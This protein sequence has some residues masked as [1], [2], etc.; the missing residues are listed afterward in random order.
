M[1]HLCEKEIKNNFIA[2]E[3]ILVF[4]SYVPEGMGIA[5]FDGEQYQIATRIFEP[6]DIVFSN[7]VEILP[8]D[9]LVSSKIYLLQVDGKFFLLDKDHHFVHRTDYVEMLGFDSFMDHSCSPNTFQV[10]S[11]KEEYTVYASKTIAVGDKITCDYQALDNTAVGNKNVGTATFK[12]LC[13]E[14]NC[15]GVLIC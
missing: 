7:R 15:Y 4:Q 5:A 9:E 3:N 10:Y 12:C 14:S 1:L 13:G 2:T 6:G 8:K 11:N